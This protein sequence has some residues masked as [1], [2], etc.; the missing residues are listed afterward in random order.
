MIDIVIPFYSQPELLESCI[1][2]I[3][4]NS[5]SGDYRVVIVNDASPDDDTTTKLFRKLSAQDAIIILAH[6]SNQGFVAAANTGFR[7]SKSN[8]VILLNSDTLVT[9]G[10]IEKLSQCANSNPRV[11]S[12]SP[13][14]N[15]GTIFSIPHINNN[16][17]L[18][19]GVTPNTMNS[20]LESLSAKQYP[21]VPTTHGFCMFIKPL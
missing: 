15:N 4:K 14:T 10:W 17:S 5:C 18:P 13:L 19:S 6:E 9:P 11:A 20:L 3:Q 12:V 21:Q 8:H 16:N 7:F 2:S 1:S